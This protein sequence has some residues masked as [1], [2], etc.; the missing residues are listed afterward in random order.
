MKVY[1]ENREIADSNKALIDHVFSRAGH[2]QLPDSVMAYSKVGPNGRPLS[3]GA[4]AW[5]R[6]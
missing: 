5:R 6:S 4:N 2:A 3:P 1:R